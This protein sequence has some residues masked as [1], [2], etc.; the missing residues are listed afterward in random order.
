MKIPIKEVNIQGKRG[1]NFPVA[2]IIPGECMGSGLGSIDSFGDYDIMSTH[3]ASQGLRMGDFVAIEDH[4][5]KFGFA[6]VKDAITVGTIVHGACLDSGHG[7]GF[8]PILSCKSK[9]LTVSLDKESNLRRYL[10]DGNQGQE[11]EETSGEEGA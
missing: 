9:E 6:Y 8:M 7:P 11:Q 5:C 1:V 10:D 4:Y 2:K 3:P